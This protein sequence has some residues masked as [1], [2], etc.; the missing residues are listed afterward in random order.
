MSARAKRNRCTS[1][2]RKPRMADARY[3]TKMTA[4]STFHEEEALGRA[5]DGRLMR[6]LLAY[7]R[8]YTGLIAGALLLLMLEGLLQLVGPLLTQYVIDVAIPARDT[9]MTTRAA[10]LMTASLVL[11]FGCSYGE[12]IFTALL[13]Q[14]VMQQLRVD[15]FSHLQRLPVPFFDRNPV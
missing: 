8:P 13:G 3:V 1:W 6:R 5:Y 7:A 9:T 15:I 2:V 14:R 4:P 11:A 12:T 10:V